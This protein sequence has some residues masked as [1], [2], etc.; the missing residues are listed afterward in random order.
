MG[1]REA[2][3]WLV[4][5]ASALL[6]RDPY[7]GFAVPTSVPGVEPHIL[8]PVKTWQDKAAFAETAKQLVD[9]FK[10]N[11]KR[12]EDHVDADVKAA[13]PTMSIAA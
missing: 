7:F 10:K 11:F 9:M 8:Y 1:G 12:F 13:E 3:H 2:A 6:R 5:S 4:R